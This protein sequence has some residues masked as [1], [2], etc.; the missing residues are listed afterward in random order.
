MSIL[1]ADC[2]DSFVYTIVDYLRSLGADVVVERADDLDVDAVPEHTTDAVLLSPGPGRP[3]QARSC[4]RLLERFANRLPILGV[5]LG[6]QVIAEHYGA[7]V[8]AADEPRHGETSP[9][10]HDGTGLFA[11]LPDPL[12]VTRYHSL[13]VAEAGLPPELVVTARTGPGEIMGLRHRDLAVSGVQFHPEAVLTESGHDLLGN[14]LAL[15]R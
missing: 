4:H 8:T 13:L 10:K 5:C 14:W 3:D 15:V 9:V 1:V 7:T 2:R 6:H 12:T 11:G